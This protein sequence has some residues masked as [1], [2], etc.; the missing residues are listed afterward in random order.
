M[1]K[2]KNRR[3][4][5]RVRATMKRA[6]RDGEHLVARLRK[7]AYGLIERSRAE[8]MK[9]VRA[10]TKTI[11]NRADRAVLDLERRVVKQFHAATEGQVKR[12]EQRIA[13]VERMLAARSMAPTTGGERAA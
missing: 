2:T 11:Q 5:A 1:A 7:D 13:R 10:V 9:D 12:L 4:L 8:V 3:P 6:T